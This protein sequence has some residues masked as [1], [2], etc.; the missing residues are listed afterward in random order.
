MSLGRNYLQKNP[1]KYH[2][3][4]C[5]RDI[6]EYSADYIIHKYVSDNNRNGKLAYQPGT[7]KNLIQVY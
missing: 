3:G 5:V 2:F 4:Q 7:D 1:Q 6:V